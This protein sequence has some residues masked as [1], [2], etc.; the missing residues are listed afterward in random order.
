N[1]KDFWAVGWFALGPGVVNPTASKF[2]HTD[3]NNLAYISHISDF[4]NDKTAN[5]CF[6]HVYRL[7]GNVGFYMSENID[8]LEYG[9]VVNQSEFRGLFV[10]Q[11]CN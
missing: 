8:L 11:I 2:N 3:E 6:W 5:D 1:Q 7:T 9:E 4:K 10:D